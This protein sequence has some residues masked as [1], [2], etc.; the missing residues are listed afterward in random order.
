VK[1]EWRKGRRGPSSDKKKR[2]TIRILL[3]DGGFNKENRKE[4]KVGE[5]ER[6]ATLRLYGDGRGQEK[7]QGQSA[8]TTTTHQQRQKIEGQKSP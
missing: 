4:K 8:T 2:V 5:S 6:R 1:S 3:E 7:T